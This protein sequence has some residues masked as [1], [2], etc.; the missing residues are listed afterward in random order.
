MKSIGIVGAGAM[1]SGIAQVAAMAGCEVLLYD[2]QPSSVDRAVVS[3]RD[4]VNK[5]L[6]KGKIDATQANAINGAIY[7]CS[8]LT[9]MADVD[10]VIE[11]IIEDIDIKK[12]VFRDLESIVKPTTILASNTSSLSITSIAAALSQPDRCIGIH[13]FNPPVLMRLVEIIP[14][15]QSSVDTIKPA[16][17]IIEN[18]GKMVVL[19]KDTPGF[20]VNKV[21]RPFYSE[22]LR[23]YDEG[24]ATKE[25]IDGAMMA[26]GFKMGP[27]ILMDF[28]GHDVNYRVTESVWR[29]FYYDPRY[30]PSITQLRLLEAEYL[31]RKSGKGFYNYPMEDIVPLHNTTISDRI[32]TMLINEAADTV[33]YQIASTQDVDNAVQYGLNYPKGLFAWAQELG[34]EYILNILHNLYHFYQEDRYRTS[35]YLKAMIKKD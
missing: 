21:A 26:V 20:I 28:I 17:T 32:L 11:A 16:T 15:V 35:P 5:L 27:F 29:S 9:A 19:A 6:S 10:L 14:A 24:L 18:W 23:I 30:K 7:P 4:S 31:G 8:T 34:I 2:A 25:E 33:H 13:F 22:A 3:I 1:G 12:Q